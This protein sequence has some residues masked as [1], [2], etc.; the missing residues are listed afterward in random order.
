[1]M[2]EATE[3][4][5]TRKRLGG[6]VTTVQDISRPV[7]QCCLPGALLEI[8]K[9]LPEEQLS[10]AMFRLCPASTGSTCAKLQPSARASRVA[11]RRARKGYLHTSMDPDES[12]PIRALPGW[13]AAM[14]T[15]G[16]KRTAWKPRKERK[17][18]CHDNEQPE[19]TRKVELAY[20]RALMEKERRYKHQDAAA[21]LGLWTSS[22]SSALH[23]TVASLNLLWSSDD[24]PMLNSYSQSYSSIHH[25]PIHSNPVQPSPL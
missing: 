8:K 6:R 16:R 25:H 21:E 15:D 12:I 5:V 9:I 13:F 20:S 14:T 23:C 7:F 18:G 11:P 1:M 3:Q 4:I 24:D 2:L 17:N 22:Q 10:I 19:Q